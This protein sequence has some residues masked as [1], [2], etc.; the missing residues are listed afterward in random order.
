M[1]LAVG[2]RDFQKSPRRDRAHP[3]SR[4][5]VQ[6]MIGRAERL[7]DLLRLLAPRRGEVSQLVGVKA[8]RGRVES[9]LLG[10]CRGGEGEGE[11]PGELS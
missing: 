6:G 7:E 3:Q 8:L 10:G 1:W 11:G 5:C 4:D 9:F 2:R